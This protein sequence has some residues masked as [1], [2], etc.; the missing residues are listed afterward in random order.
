MTVRRYM[1]ST[2][3]AWVFTAMFIILPAKPN[4]NSAAIS[5]RRL[6]ARPMPTSNVLYNSA[7]QLTTLRLP[8]IPTTHPEPANDTIQPTAKPGQ[9]PNSGKRDHDR[10]PVHGFHPYRLGIHVNF[11]HI[12]GKTEQEQRGDQQQTTFSQANAH[13]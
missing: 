1:A 9:T 5:I 3:T 4:K 8:N 11:H 2:P 10:P 7:A 6:S 12:A 13:Q